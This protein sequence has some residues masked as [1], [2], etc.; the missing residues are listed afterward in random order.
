MEEI[1]DGYRGIT[2]ATSVLYFRFGVSVSEKFFTIT[3]TLSK[4]VQRKSLCAV[5]LSSNILCYCY[6]GMFERRAK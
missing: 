4:A 2:E 6:S 5:E 3:D 1:L